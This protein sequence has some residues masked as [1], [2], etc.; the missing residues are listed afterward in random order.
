MRAYRPPFAGKRSD[1]NVICSLVLEQAESYDRSNI[2]AQTYSYI[3]LG[4]RVRVNKPTGT[5]HFVY[6]SQGRVVAEY[7]ASASEVKAELIGALP[8]PAAKPETTSGIAN[9]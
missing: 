4:D 7:G 8:P 2:S 9:C 1:R 3:G 5:R 6:D